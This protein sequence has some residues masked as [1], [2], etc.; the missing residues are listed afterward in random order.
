MNSYVNAQDIWG[1]FH[2]Y[3]KDFFIYVGMVSQLRII[4]PSPDSSYFLLF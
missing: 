2:K 3:E 1:F 4:E